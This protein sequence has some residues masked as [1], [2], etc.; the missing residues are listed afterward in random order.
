[1]LAGVRHLACNGDERLLSMGSGNIAQ[2][3]K[4]SRKQRRVSGRRVSVCKVYQQEEANDH[5]SS[6]GN[7]AGARYPDYGGKCKSSRRGLA[8]PSRI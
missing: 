7:I 8:Q 6:R 5:A 3:G 1:M 4:P 2:W